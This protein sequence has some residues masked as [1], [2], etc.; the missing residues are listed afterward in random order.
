MRP[1]AAIRSGHR[2]VSRAD[3]RFVTDTIAIEYGDSKAKSAGNAVARR[4]AFG[5]P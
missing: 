1:G 4:R 5:Y 3:S 2:P